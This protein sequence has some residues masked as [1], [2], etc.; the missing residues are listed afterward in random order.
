MYRSS[1]EII[2]TDLQENLSFVA[3]RISGV[4]DIIHGVERAIFLPQ[5]F[6]ACIQFR[7]L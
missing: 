2:A 6:I 5:T 7:I 4:A 1:C 3:E